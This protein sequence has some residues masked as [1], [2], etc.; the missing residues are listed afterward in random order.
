MPTEIKNHFRNRLIPPLTAAQL[1]SVGVDPT[2]LWFSPTFNEWAF[3]GPLCVRFPYSSTG[4]IIQAL[5]LTP[6]PEA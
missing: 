4:S 3:A 2:D 5:G 6:N 1:Q